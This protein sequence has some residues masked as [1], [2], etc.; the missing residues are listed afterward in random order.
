MA[1]AV[2]LAVLAIVGS[3]RRPRSQDAFVFAYSTSV[4]P[5]VNGRIT[6]VH[7]R[8]NQRVA[9]DEILVEIERGPYEFKLAQAR[10]QVAALQA[11]IEVAA[12]QVASQSTAAK[13]AATQ[14]QGALSQLDL[15]KKHRGSASLRSWTKVMRRRNNSMRRSPKRRSRDPR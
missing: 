15:A 3:D 9:K 2:L 10:A 11:Q 1:A 12:R 7:V 4:V 13:A 14:I 6:G 5:E 8:E